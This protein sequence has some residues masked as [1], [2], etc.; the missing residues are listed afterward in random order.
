MKSLMQTAPVV[1]K[2]HSITV[3]GTDVEKLQD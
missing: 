3:M 2:N 1:T